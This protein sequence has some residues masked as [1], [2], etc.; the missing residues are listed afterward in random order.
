MN[1]DYNNIEIIIIDDCSG[2]NTENIINN[3]IK[4]NS[5][6][7]RSYKFTKKVGAGQARQKGIY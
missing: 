3:L 1:Q 5:N 2:D 4:E 6:I 7:I